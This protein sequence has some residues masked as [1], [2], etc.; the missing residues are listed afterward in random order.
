MIV[1][2]RWIDYS[3][4]HKKAFINFDSRIFTTLIPFE[5]SVPF[6]K[7]KNND[8]YFSVSGFEKD[9]KE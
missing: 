4:E 7:L 3:I 1:S 2:H 8:I 5:H 6:K 9:E